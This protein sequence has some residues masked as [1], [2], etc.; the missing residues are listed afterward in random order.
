M[1]AQ[2]KLRV[3]RARG[4]PLPDEWVLTKE[5]IPSRDPNDYYNSGAILPVGG[6]RGGHEGYALG[7]MV[8]L[9]GS[10]QGELVWP[11]L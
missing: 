7:F 4:K 10:V 3:Y 1:A 6:V 5:G 9:L 11:E 8:A 2:G